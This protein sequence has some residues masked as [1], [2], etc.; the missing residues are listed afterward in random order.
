MCQSPNSSLIMTKAPVLPTRP[1]SQRARRQS[2]RLSPSTPIRAPKKKLKLTPLPLP[3]IK[4]QLDKVMSTAT[5]YL[6]IAPPNDEEF[7]DYKEKVTHIDL[8]IISERIRRGYYARSSPKLLADIRQVWSNALSYFPPTHIRYE[9]AAIKQEEF[10]E[11]L[12]NAQKERSCPIQALETR[13]ARLEKGFS[14]VL[15]Q[16]RRRDKRTGKPPTVKELQE[17]AKELETLPDQY[18]RGLVTLAPNHF[19]TTG[20]DLCE[21]NLEKVTRD[22]FVSIRKYL[23]TCKGEPKPPPT[24]GTSQPALP[25]PSDKSQPAGVVPVEDEF[26]QRIRRGQAEIMQARGYHSDSSSSDSGSDCRDNGIF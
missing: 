12:V 9:Q 10:E 5:A 26:V 18:R 1:P 21:V 23:R 13:I 8:T 14:E 15:A 24:E 2:A 22:E 7:P 4:E 3:K 19:Q 6:F 25:E 20:Q 17:L 16:L 11:L